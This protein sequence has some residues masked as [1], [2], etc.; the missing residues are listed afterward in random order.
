[1]IVYVSFDVAD[2]AISFYFSCSQAEN[3]FLLN[4]ML[5]IGFFGETYTG[6]IKEEGSAEWAWPAEA[7][8]SFGTTPRTAVAYVGQIAPVRGLSCNAYLPHKSAGKGT[9]SPQMLQRAE[10]D[11]SMIFRRV[12]SPLLMLMEKHSLSWVGNHRLPLPHWEIQSACCDV[13]VILLTRVSRQYG[14]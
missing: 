11:T 10:M 14:L 13:A 2:A 6:M 12:P 9:F 1:M 3:N 8:S 7:V 4:N 5:W